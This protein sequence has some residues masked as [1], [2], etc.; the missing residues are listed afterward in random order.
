MYTNLMLNGASR[1]KKY[2]GNSVGSQVAYLSSMIPDENVYPAETILPGRGRNFPG[3]I[4]LEQPLNTAV[5]RREYRLGPGRH[6][7]LGRGKAGTH[8]F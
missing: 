8:D 4:D 1:R 2:V 5:A 7:K 6:C 3:A